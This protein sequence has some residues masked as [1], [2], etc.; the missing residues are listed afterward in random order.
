MSRFPPLI[1][2]S[3]SDKIGAAGICSTNGIISI[4]T[5]F[6]ACFIIM[7]FLHEIWHYIFNNYIPLVFKLKYQLTISMEEISHDLMLLLPEPYRE[8]AIIDEAQLMRYIMW[9]CS[10]YSEDSTTKHK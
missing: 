7:I 9:E 10:V 8:R 5:D 3:T 2:F 4:A 1:L 6:P